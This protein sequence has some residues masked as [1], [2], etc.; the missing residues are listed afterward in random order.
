MKTSLCDVGLILVYT[1]SSW[2]GNKT[3]S[4]TSE[5]VAMRANSS[6]K[7]CGKYI[8]R[9][10]GDCEELQNISKLGQSI[11]N[12]VKDSTLPYGRGQRLVPSSKFIVLMN[13]LAQKKKE[14]E[15]LV[16][17]FIK[18]YPDLVERARSTQVLMFKES[19]CPSVEYLR[20]H[21][22]FSIEVFPVPQ[23]NQFDGIL[24]LADLEESYKAEF[25]QA[26]LRIIDRCKN[27]ILIKIKDSVEHAVNKLE[28]YL[29]NPSEERFYKSWI[30]NVWEES[31]KADEFNLVESIFI[32]D[33]CRE[34]LMLEGRYI[35]FDSIRHNT[36]NTTNDLLGEFRA[37]VDRIDNELSISLITHGEVLHVN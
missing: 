16:E 30:S 31:K 12:W 36:S 32:S 37:V 6:R 23:S 13:D 24:G 7:E 11:R 3:D 20:E 8:K 19:D 10:L 28:N 15:D 21:F 1:I 22:C 4:E 17:V 14:Y 2:T 34:I 35:N 29:S 18:K 33:V 27:Q 25:E 5:D 9:I 26:Q